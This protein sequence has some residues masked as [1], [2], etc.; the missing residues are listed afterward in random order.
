MS[1]ISSKAG[2]GSGSGTRTV[3]R[4]GM[5]R[6]HISIEGAPL[7]MV[8]NSSGMPGMNRSSGNGPNQCIG[9]ATEDFS[10]FMI[11]TM[12]PVG[13]VI[14][15]STAAITMSS[16]PMA[17]APGIGQ[18]PPPVES[19]GGEE[20]LSFARTPKPTGFVLRHR[21]PGQRRAMPERGVA[22]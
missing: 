7:R 19:Q 1:G 11:R 22:A 21:E 12:V 9:I 5:P 14:P 3:G 6:S 10:R 4:R 20:G 8:A 18:R 2:P 17:A 15:P 16:R 13:S